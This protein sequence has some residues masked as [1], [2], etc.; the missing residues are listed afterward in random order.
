M[1]VILLS[2]VIDSFKSF[3]SVCLPWQGICIQDQEE[4]VLKHSFHSNLLGYVGVSLKVLMPTSHFF[5]DS[6]KSFLSICHIVS[7]HSQNYLTLKNREW[8]E[9]F[10][11]IFNFY[12][13]IFFE[14]L[15]LEQWLVVI[16]HQN[17]MTALES[18]NPTILQN[19]CGDYT[20]HI[21]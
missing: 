13:I 2:K 12:Q 18:S 7:S 5:A 6:F 14:A 19:I 1:S 3:P 9:D 20:F 15:W 17:Q 11:L 10:S 21:F 4:E 16:C 8:M